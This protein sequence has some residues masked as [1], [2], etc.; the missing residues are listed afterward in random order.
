MKS[1][2]FTYRVDV[3]DDGSE[4]RLLLICDR[5]GR[6]LINSWRMHKPPIYNQELECILSHLV[7]CFTRPLSTT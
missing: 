3:S 6:E 5:C 7:E 1:G 4:E 2:V